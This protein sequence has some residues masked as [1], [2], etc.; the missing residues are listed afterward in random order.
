ML[1]RINHPKKAALCR[2]FFSIPILLLLATL[3]GASTTYTYDAAGRLTSVNYGNGTVLSYTYDKAGNL[4]Q[5][6]ITSACDVNHAGATVIT[7]V[8]TLIN[9]AL[10]VQ[11]A[12]H[13]L[14]SD[15]LVN[16]V[17]VETVV[18]AALGR[19]CSAG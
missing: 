14:N 5:R 8:Q 9:E 6:S 13:D 11:P 15:G 18:Q 7:D 1:Q 17:D 12:A 19:G 3:A 4:L 10:G 16:V 2:M